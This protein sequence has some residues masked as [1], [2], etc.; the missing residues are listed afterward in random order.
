MGINGLALSLACASWTEWVILYALYVRQE[1]YSTQTQKDLMSFAKFAI[2]GSVMALILGVVLPFI[3]D[4][5]TAVTWLTLL[6]GII[7]GAIIYLAFA[8]VLKLP[9][10]HEIRK[11]I[12]SIIQR[13]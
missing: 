7:A 3:K 6:I 2:C 9:E 11:R 10:E 13:F 5:S 8:R 4:G 12:Q 1:G